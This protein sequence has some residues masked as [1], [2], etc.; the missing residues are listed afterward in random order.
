MM[1]GRLFGGFF[2]VEVLY[3]FIIILCSLMI[4]FGT[5]ELYELSYHKGIRYFRLAFL[6]F[7]FAYFFRS[8][9]KFILFY[10][11]VYEIFSISSFLFNL[12]ISHITLFLFMYFSSIAVFY[13]LYSVTYKRFDE[14]GKKIF[15]FHI[16][17]V[18]IAFFSV[19]SRNPLM[20]LFLNFVLFL[21][22]VVIVLFAY[23]NS[24]NKRLKFNLYFVYLLLLFFWLM[25]II[26]ILI[27]NFFKSYQLIIYL[28]SVGFF[29]AVLY[30]VL[31]KAGD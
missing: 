17:A 18:I 27:P 31:R 3:S 28:F 10:F 2:G 13:L 15:L 24:K 9:V 21:F 23:H 11:N 16:L 30:K 22:V 29:M 7:A 5:R 25:N 26:D 14:S 4:Y 6:F 12:L 19:F 8:F 20:Y 1:F